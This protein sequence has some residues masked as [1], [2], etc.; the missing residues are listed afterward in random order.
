MRVSYPIAVFA[1]YAD[2]IIVHCRAESQAKYMLRAIELRL[3]RCKLKLNPQKTKIFYCKDATRPGSYK[4]ESFDFL[5]YGFR[6]RLCKGRNCFVGFTPAISKSAIKEIGCKDKRVEI[7]A[8]EFR[9]F[10]GY[11]QSN[12]PCG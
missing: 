1:R 12:Q 10:G 5:G 6:A 8:V 3:A 2:D 11:C 7:A 9:F 4:H